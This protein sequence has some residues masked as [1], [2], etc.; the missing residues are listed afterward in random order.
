MTS[1]FKKQLDFIAEGVDPV[2]LVHGLL[3]EDWR[4]KDGS[5]AYPE[6]GSIVIK[7]G[8]NE[9]FEVTNVDFHKGC[10]LKGQDNQEVEC[11][12]HEFWKQYS[13]L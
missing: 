5:R 12:P 3:T 7:N 1:W 8:G 9:V 4:T 10:R 6:H 13:L 11:P 2:N